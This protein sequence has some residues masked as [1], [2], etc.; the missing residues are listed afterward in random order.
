VGF[1]EPTV[2][3]FLNGSPILPGGEVEIDA[4]TKEWNLDIR[5]TFVISFYFF[6]EIFNLKI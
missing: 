2:S 6:I 1:P 5:F 3:W 4:Y